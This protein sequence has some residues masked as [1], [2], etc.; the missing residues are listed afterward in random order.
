MKVLSV[1]DVPGPVEQEI[2]VTTRTFWFTRRYQGSGAIYF[3]VPN[4]K[5]ASRRLERYFSEL[6][7][8]RRQSTT[9]APTGA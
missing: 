1:E 7:E 5:R 2:L 6:Y 3:R 4:W 9:G 8:Q